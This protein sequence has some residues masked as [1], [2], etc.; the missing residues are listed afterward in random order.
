[1]IEM[2]CGM[3]PE[4]AAQGVKTQF[5]NLF[6]EGN[7][8]WTESERQW[9]WKEI[10]ANIM[11]GKEFIGTGHGYSLFHAFAEI[12]H[13]HAVQLLVE[14]GVDIDATTAQDWTAVHCAAW[15]GHSAMVRALLKNGSD[16]NATAPLHDY[17]ALHF[18]AWRGH[19]AVVRV[20]LEY[21]DVDVRLSDGRTALY[22]AAEG[23]HYAVVRLLVEN[24]ADVNVRTH[25]DDTPLR[26]AVAMG[27]SAITQ[28]L[29]QKG[30]DVTAG[31]S[32]AS[33]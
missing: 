11:N 8:E 10:R 4:Q 31:E 22:M 6:L 29:L 27:N 14:K 9:H 17:T 23:R 30:A 13:E 25:D 2:L 33:H 3:T 7:P 24:G 12:G 16:V 32:E 1:M 18:A 5:L 15:K 20:L 19:E 26:R 28:L 21:I